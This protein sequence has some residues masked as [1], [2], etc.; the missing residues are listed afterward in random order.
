MS[1]ERETL[2]AGSP[3]EETETNP[4]EV[5]A[6]IARATEGGAPAASDAA[7]VEAGTGTDAEAGESSAAPV[8]DADAAEAELEH[9]R[10]ASL[11]DTQLDLERPE[12]RP[13][14]APAVDE[15]PSAAAS[16]TEASDLSDLGPE[17]DGEIRIS[18][19]HPMAALYVQTPMPPE[20][21][22]N[23]GAG[24]LIA[25]V[26][27]VGFALVYAGV[28][29][30]WIAPSFPPSTY[31]SEGLVPLLTSW[32]FI[33]ATAAFF[34]GLVIVVLV[35]GRAG[36]WAYVLGGFFVALLVWAATVVGLRLVLDSNLTVQGPLWQ[37]PVGDPG[38][39]PVEL[40]RSLGFSVPALAAALVAREATVWFGAWIGSR[41]RR[42]TAR[43][44]AAIDEYETALE[45]SR[46]A[47]P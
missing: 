38:W 2:P 23:R 22:G 42:V 41:G 11:V 40:V 4:A 14:I 25:L 29:A 34:V 35:V 32:A 3:V 45:E 1:E 13:V 15:L 39:N 6:A 27:T 5:D 9:R 47:K 16:K 12:P 44:R 20:I 24:V 33:A 46:T 19:D 43:N 21:R 26:A 17:R 28:L 36:W 37:Q 30:L 10:E 7:P 18:A 31:F 8:A